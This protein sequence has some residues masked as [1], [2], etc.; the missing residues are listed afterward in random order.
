M[1]NPEGR[2]SPVGSVT[3]DGDYAT[4][5]FSRRIG[6]PPEDVWSAITDPE[7]LQGWYMT[8]ATIAGGK[9][10]SI[11]FVSGPSQ[12]HITGR[13]LSWDPPHLFEHEWRVD[14]RPDLPSGEESLVRWELAREGHETLMTFTFRRLTRRTAT[15]FAPGMHAFLDRL[16]AQLDGES[17]P[18]WT[19]LASRMR[20]YYPPWQ[21]SS[22]GKLS[23]QA[24]KAEGSRSRSESAE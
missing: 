23:E 8:R 7:Q 21:S 22:P 11:D 9:G 17:V 4:I 15:G 2:V 16:V 12:L 6:H 1:S 14:P 19:S 3:Y 18:E 10:G 13:I 20:G 24:Q 5:T